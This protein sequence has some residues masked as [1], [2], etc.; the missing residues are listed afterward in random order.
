MA[1][2]ENIY[3]VSDLTNSKSLLTNNIEKSSWLEKS[4]SVLK[5]VKIFF[6]ETT[7]E[8]CLFMYMFCTSL[9]SMAVQNMHLDKSCRVNFNFSDNIC[10]RIRDLN[11]TNL[12]NELVQVQT[13]VAKVTAWKFPLQTAIP[14]VLVLFVGA[15]SD[16]YKK[17]KICILF[18]FTGEIIVNIGLIFA[19]YYF[20]ELSLTATALIEALPAALSGSYIIIFM[21]MYSF[22]ADRTT[23]ENRTFRLGV[24]T[25]FVSFGTPVGTALSGILLRAL[26][27][28]GIFSLLIFLHISS[29]IY[30][31]FRLEDVIVDKEISS[32]NE[33]H[34]NRFQA[35][36]RDVLKM[37]CN[38][39]LVALRPRA[40][41][42]RTQI[43]LVI[44][45]YLLMVGPLYGDSQVSYLYARRKFNLN[46]VEYSIY[47]TINI[48]LGL[49]GTIFCITVLSRKFNVQDS[50]LGG[51]AGVSRIASCFVFA[52]AP[53]RPWYYSAPLFNIFSHTGLTAVRS[54][55]SKSVPT[56]EVAKLNAL[57]GV[58][59][60]IAPSIYTPTS[61]YIYA[62]TIQNF[63]GAFYL[64]DA[65]LT[66]VALG[67]FT[68]I[69][70]IVK[71]RMRN[72]VAN[73]KRK[74]EFARSNEVSRF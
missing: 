52:F 2:T 5:K 65:A 46:E 9:S 17:R 34:Q 6:R 3:S 38:T 63:P 57:I 64:F 40:F 32:V 4:K 12:E 11:T 33:T 39:V 60:A 71:R 35:I 53:N 74:E 55:A 10:D 28:Y 41:N 66:V 67:L 1:S 27:Y 37:V 42:G 23:I 61:S 13:L 8:P 49:V 62:A 51:L 70:V 68:C 7:V 36:L 45:L 58:M 25:I 56:E 24:V 20:R 26:G 50:A 14:A 22:M 72:A 21:G 16:K 31:L 73:P 18:P 48:L 69:Y 47:G 29:F 15:W 43:F 30:G 44:I 54:I 59:E 19:T